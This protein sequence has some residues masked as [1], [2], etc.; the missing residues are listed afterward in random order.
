MK[1]DGI[2]SSAARL[3][4]H[5][6]PGTATI[7]ADAQSS[8]H[9]VAETDS[10][11]NMDSWSSVD[12]VTPAPH[13]VRRPSRFSLVRSLLHEHRTS[14]AITC[15]A[16]TL[17][18]ALSCAWVE[19]G[20]A[21]DARDGLPDVRTLTHYE[22]GSNIS[23]Y[24]TSAII[25]ETAGG[26]CM[27]VTLLLV[28]SSVGFLIEA[29]RREYAMMRL[30][31]AS[32]RRIR[33]MALAEFA[34]PCGLAD[35]AGCL[36]GLPLVPTLGIAVARA[37]DLNDHAF[38]PRLRFGGVA[39]TFFL[40]LLSCI[41]GVWF[42]AHRISSVSPLSALTRETKESKS[43][44]VVRM[45]AAS[46]VAALAV[47][48]CVIPLSGMDI[49]TRTSLLTVFA[50]LALYLFAP[51][52]LPLLA[53]LFGRVAQRCSQG[54]GLLARQRAGKQRRSTVAIGLPV[55]LVVF[56]V[57]A[58]MMMAQAGSKESLMTQFQPM[59]A[60]VVVQTAS[61]IL[62]D[63]VS[64]AL[65]AQKNDIASSVVYHSEDWAGVNDQPVTV[66]TASLSGV[67][68]AGPNAPTFVKGSLSALGPHKVAVNAEKIAPYGDYRLGQNVTFYGKADHLY[69]ATIV[70]VVESPKGLGSN[71]TMNFF[72]LEGAFG[73]GGVA[74]D[75]RFVPI[76]LRD[77]VSASGFATRF[78]Q[79]MGFV[80]ARHTDKS[81]SSGVMVLTKPEYIDYFIQDHRSQQHALAIVIVG[82][83]ALAAIFLIQSCA[84][85][86]T[87]R[88]EENRRLRQ[89]GVSQGSVMSAAIWES[90]LDVLAASALAVIGLV[91]VFAELA[92][93]YAREGISPWAVPVPVGT[94]TGIVAIILV[95]AVLTSAI[96]TFRDCLGAES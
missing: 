51:L 63:K 87:E 88:R 96:C 24:S 22:R 27:L 89:L 5:G 94:L 76:V 50:L 12:E 72:A 93:Q 42:A 58:F 1:S 62:A 41:A 82:G 2:A 32:A 34:V 9:T 91:S 19:L 78:A 25:C 55:V 14:Y 75:G 46:L 59:R 80:E 92:A 83:A 6:I 45:V 90:V 47:C 16:V 20:Q 15:L 49:M 35:L 64:A 13:R 61:R 85:V 43:V 77:G 84:I 67:K 17:A 74:D 68:E 81:N 57:M 52:C 44:G 36:L 95:V 33:V 28:L 65:Q 73:N 11:W 8:E 3:T 4:R 60:D 86:I 69:K 38:A 7:V 70:A 71:A 18:S 29:R 54:S 31:G 37:M 30:S 23:L 21:M 79:H 56:I 40:V 48:F 53:S 10:V 26:A 66:T 39:L